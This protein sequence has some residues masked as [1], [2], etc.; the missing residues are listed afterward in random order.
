[1][2]GDCGAIGTAQSETAR[3]SDVN[4]RPEDVSLAKSVGDCFVDGFAV[5]LRTAGIR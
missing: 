4:M 5:S 1:M 3:F 2:D